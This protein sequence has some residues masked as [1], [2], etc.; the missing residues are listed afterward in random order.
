MKLSKLERDLVQA[1]RLG[2]A[3]ITALCADSR[4]V[5]RGD[6]FFCFRGT[7]T[8]AHRYAKEAVARGAAAIV[9][10]TQLPLDCPQLVVPDGREAMARISATFYGHPEQKLKMIAVTG[11]NGKTTTVHLLYRIFEAAG[12][13]AGIIGTLGARFGTR[14][15]SPSLTTPDPVAL[16]SLLADMVKSG[17]EVVAME[18]S[19]HAL[20][21]KKDAPI[22]YDVA[23]FTNLTR[24][25]L[26]FFGDMTAY[27]RAKASL[28]TPERCRFAVLNA[29]DA[30]SETLKSGGISYCTYGLDC[31]AEAFAMVEEHSLKKSRLI[32]NLSDTLLETELY[33]S[34][35]HNVYNALAAAVAAKRLGVSSDAIARGIS[36]TKEVE[37]RLEWVGNFRGADLFVDFAHTPDGLEK[38]LASLREDCQGRL[39]LVFGCGGNRDAGKR[40]AMGEIAAKGCDFCVITSD[41]PRYEDPCAIIAEIERG[42]R[43]ISSRYVAVEERER[44]IEYALG[45]LQKG[46]ILL[47][48]GKGAE[49]TQEIMG[50]KYS[51]ND[52]TVIKSL[53]EKF[54]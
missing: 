32:L 13:R 11:T 33:L 38:S 3:E 28:F 10:E 27:G 9:C 5:R 52:K 44:A 47:V 18:V 8:D 26:D 6:L 48:A 15:V 35:R 20:A 17:V 39:L 50:I 19:A 2:E 40:A 1:K 49:T 36:A 21:L 54:S 41:N 12:K 24:D 43:K 53:L 22:C 31:P 29:D 7:K 37:G 23:I 30:F 46:D 42:Y 45:K 25:H 16:F 4:V 14:S 34:G 51:Y